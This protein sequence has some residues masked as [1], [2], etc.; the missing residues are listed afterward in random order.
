[1]PYVDPVTEHAGV[2]Q[3]TTFSTDGDRWSQLIAS[4]HQMSE[5]ARGAE[6][7]FGAQVCS[8]EDRPDAVA[9]VSRWRSRADLDGWL[10]QS[11][12]SAEASAEELTGGPPTTQTL[13]SLPPH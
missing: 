7:C 12:G 4:L 3:I 2:V 13:T 1:M 11:G 8:V 10:S 6:G 5:Q 9:V